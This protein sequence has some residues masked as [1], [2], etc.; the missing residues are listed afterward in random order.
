MKKPAAVAACVLI[1]GEN[2]QAAVELAELFKHPALAVCTLVSYSFSDGLPEI[3]HESHQ[4]DIV[5][6][7]VTGQAGLP[8]GSVTPLTR[9]AAPLVM[10]SATEIT[11]PAL[12]SLA[13]QCI[14]AIQRKDLSPALLTCLIRQ[15]T[16]NRQLRNSL[17][18]SESRYAAVLDSIADGVVVCNADGNIEAMNPMAEQIFACRENEVLTKNLTELFSAQGQPS[19]A[20]FIHDTEVQNAATPPRFAQEMEGIR[21]DGSCFPLE[22]LISRTRLSNREVLTCIVRDITLSKQKEQELQLTATAFETHTAILITRVDGTILRVNPAFTQI[23]GYTAEEAVGNNPKMLQSGHHGKEFYEK[24]WHTIKTTGKWEGEIWNKRKNGEVY[25]E[26]QTITAVKNHAAEVTHYVATFQD[27]TERKQTQAVIE[28]HAFYDALTNLPN[29]RMMLDRLNQEL[30]AARRRQDYGAL[31][32]LDLDH[33]KILNDS[34]GHAVGDSLLQQMA[35]RLTNHVRVEDTV[36]RLGGDEFVVLLSNLGSNEKSATATANAIAKKI[37]VA[38]SRPYQLEGHSFNFT[39]SMGITLFPSAY[40]SADD[41]LKHADAAMYRAKDKGRNALCFYQSGMQTEADQRLQL[42]KELREAFSNNELEL[43]YQ[44]QYNNRSELVGVEALLRWNH[45]TGGIVGPN[46]FIALAEETN[47]IQPMGVWVMETAIKQYIEWLNSGLFSGRE[48]ISINVSA[49]QIQQDDFVAVIASI[50]A[51]H[52][53]S[54]HCLKLEI[55]ESVLLHDLLDVVTKM[56][57]LKELGVSFSMDDFGTGFSSLSYLKRLP[58]DQIK[59]DKTFIRDISRDVNDAVI[60]ETI[61]AMAEHLNL[62]VIAE[63]VETR[64]EFE[65]LQRKGCANYQGFYFSVPLQAQ[66]FEQTIRQF[67]NNSKPLAGAN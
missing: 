53:I 32:F 58:F 34:M 18:E 17:A 21:A 5:F 43:Y 57:E 61:I 55:T 27:I 13:A 42:E 30:S 47:L 12:Q 19:V 26:W 11:S 4:F 33:F 9:L 3:D 15:V 36:S 25:P 10:I 64:E 60:V 54:P 51:A 14:E 45:P 24:L 49:R 16:A 28:H 39:S 37:Q 62:D 41:V 29:R 56:N 38:I 66:S 35:K 22:L 48:Y 40:E 8:Q 63:G 52:T 44:P 6:L 31:L 1:I 2:Q 20:R 59:I 23:T 46:D 7:S 50:L 67:Q 65:F